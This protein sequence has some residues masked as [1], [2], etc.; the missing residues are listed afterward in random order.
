MKTKYKIG[1]VVHYMKNDKV[2]TRTIEG[3]SIHQGEI[4]DVGMS[5]KMDPGEYE[6]NYH[7]GTCD[8]A[9]EEGCFYHLDDLWK[10]LMDNRK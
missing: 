1:D 6:V 9:K 10:S 2:Q 7:F 3:I 8:H 4:I 5:V